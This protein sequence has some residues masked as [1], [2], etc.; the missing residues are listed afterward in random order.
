MGFKLFNDLIT[1]FE[2]GKI[3][4][5]KKDEIDKIYFRYMEE[6]VMLEICGPYFKSAYREGKITKKGFKLISSIVKEFEK[7]AQP[8]AKRF[9]ILLKRSPKLAKKIDL[10]RKSLQDKFLHYT[11]Y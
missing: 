5:L 3:V 9:R 7:V 2:H 1:A 10:L 4:G 8:S 11:A 6:K